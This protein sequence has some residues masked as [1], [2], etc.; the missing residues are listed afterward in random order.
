MKDVTAHLDQEALQGSRVRLQDLQ[1]VASPGRSGSQPPDGPVHLRLVRPLMQYDQ[2]LTGHA[3][4]RL[5]HR[6]HESAGTLCH[7]KK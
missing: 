1:Q 6:E 4:R 2:V 7:R 5:E 3:P